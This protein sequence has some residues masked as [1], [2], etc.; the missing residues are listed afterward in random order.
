MTDYT[1]AENIDVS[2]AA[3]KRR[4]KTDARKLY[5]KTW[6]QN[7]CEHLKDYF[8]KHYE[9]TKKHNPD[10]LRDSQKRASSTWRRKH[11]AQIRAYMHG[12]RKRKYAIDKRRVLN[13][14]YR[15]SNRAMLVT[16][17]RER[18][19]RYKYGLTLVRVD[20]IVSDQNGICPI[21]TQPWRPNERKVVD[22]CHKSGLVRGVLHVSC[23]LLLGYA[24]DRIGILENA[25]KYL[26]QPR[27]IVP[28]SKEKE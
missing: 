27:D 7:H 5:E 4:P 24:K 26:E 20:E 11:F 28:H 2:V 25:I 19:L 21:C 3:K 12:Y 1:P 14:E 13:T 6:R 23:N 17:E 15:R 16:K 18:K 22:H 10:K 9:H 8:R